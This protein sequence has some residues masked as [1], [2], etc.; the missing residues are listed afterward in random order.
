MM[1][2]METMET[3][4]RELLGKLC[5]DSTV[6]VTVTIYRHSEML[7]VMTN[8]HNGFRMW[9]LSD[10]L[11][12]ESYWHQLFHEYLFVLSDPEC[13]EKAGAVIASLL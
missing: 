13:F 3:W 7:S 12:I 9:I 2:M 6:Q 1:E 4:L 10:T 8:D 5:P 11:V